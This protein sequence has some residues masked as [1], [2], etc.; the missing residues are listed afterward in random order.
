MQLFHFISGLPRSGSTLLSAIL[1]QNPRFHAGMTSPVGALF[2]GVLE[3]CSA[4]SEFGAVIGTEMRRRLLRGLFDS[5]YADK[6]DKPVVFDTNRQWSSRLPAIS[7]LFPQAKVIA[8]VRNVAWV[9][10]SL[11]RLYRANPYE[12]TKL[13]GDAVE[14]N[15]VYSRCETLAQRNRLVGF[16][17]AA[18]KEAYY[19]EHADSLLIVDYDLLTQAPERVLRLVYDFIGEPW[20][21]HDFEHL[22][23]DAPEFDQALGVA[24]L[25]KVKPKVALQSRRT[26]LPPDLFKQYA[27]LSFWLDGSASAANVIRMKSDAAIS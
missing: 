12:N 24:G 15:T 1:L 16:A 11:E 23:Y 19:G 5:Y 21:E 18:L 17:W 4:G 7:D 26:I 14:R 6:A 25:H 13:F 27:D 8:C 9:M 22:A 2:S 10:D 3:Q 20:F